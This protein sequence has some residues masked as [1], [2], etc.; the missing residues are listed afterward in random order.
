M[1]TLKYTSHNGQLQHPTFSEYY[2][3]KLPD[4]VWIEET[5]GGNYSNNTTFYWPITDKPDLFDECIYKVNNIFQELANQNSVIYEP[6][7]VIKYYDD[8]FLNVK[9]Y[10]GNEQRWLE[11][12][13]FVPIN[14]PF[15]VQLTVFVV[16]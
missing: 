15:S 5:N 14:G 3:F 7:K 4:S 13:R 2:R 16:Q 10:E 9:K 6:I 11:V 8:D 1:K 12:S